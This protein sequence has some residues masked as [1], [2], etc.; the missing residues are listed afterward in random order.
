[1]RL[2]NEMRTDFVS[3]VM[4][5]VPWKNTMTDELAKAEFEKRGFERLPDDV[6]AVLK[7][8]PGCVATKCDGPENMPDVLPHNKIRGYYTSRYFSTTIPNII[9]AKDIPFDDIRKMVL[10]RDAEDVKRHEM[11]LQLQG[12]VNHATTTEEL[13]AALPEFKQWLPKPPPKR[14]KTMALAPIG[15]VA[16]FKKAGLPVATKGVRK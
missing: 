2:T 13:E 11:R 4:A 3:A 10:L 12:V 8:Y 7:K 1:M 16:Q 14:A 5:A 6:K 9:E 15:L